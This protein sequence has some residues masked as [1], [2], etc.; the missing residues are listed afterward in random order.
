[1]TPLQAELVEHIPELRRLA[2]AL[3]RDRS[4]ADDLVQETLVRALRKLDLYEP[5]GPFAGWL[6]TIMRNLFIDRTRRR[7]L[8]PE[9]PVDVLPQ[10]L[11]PRS[12]GDPSDRLMLR[13]LDAA[14]ELLPPG[15][16]E[17]LLLIGLRGH[18]YEDVAA[19][20][21][22][23]LGTV[24]SRLFRARETLMRRL[25]A[26]PAAIR[27]ARAVARPVARRADPGASARE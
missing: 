3:E 5:S 9:E 27:R 4:A 23:P 17:V 7:R 13:E 18:S 2:R 19:Q 16:R 14:I 25:E 22:L 8:K 12:K 11:E 10:A 1:M 15:Q 24:R 20:L 6:A 21:D 26:N